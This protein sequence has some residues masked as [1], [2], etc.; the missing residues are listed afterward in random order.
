MECSRCKKQIGISYFPKVYLEIC[1]TI[2]FSHN[3]YNYLQ[4]RLVLCRR[5]S[6]AFDRFMKENDNG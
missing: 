5:C 1:H 2:L 6:N 4:Q 3:P